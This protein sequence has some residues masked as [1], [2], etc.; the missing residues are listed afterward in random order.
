MARLLLMKTLAEQVIEWRNATGL[1]QTELAEFM[2][3]KQQA[4][5][6]LES[7]TTKRPKYLIELLTFFA[8]R[9]PERHIFE[10]YPVLREVKKPLAVA[11]ETALPLEVRD[12]TQRFQVIPRGSDQPIE[13]KDLPVYASAAGGEGEVMVSYDPIEW[14]ARPE[15]LEKVRD[16]Y[17]LYVV[18]DSMEPKVSSGDIVKVHPTRPPRRGN[19]VVVVLRD[20]S[21]AETGE[22]RCLVKD[23][24]SRDLQHT[25]LRQHNPFREFDIPEADIESVHLVTDTQYGR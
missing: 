6:Q 1:S 8:E 2:G 11:P 24:V 14:I 22:R 19:M 3:V 18:N 17:A 4:I 9:L 23:L 13:K 25:V 7:G 12:R 5:Q 10:M 21:D 20:R 16:A 15:T